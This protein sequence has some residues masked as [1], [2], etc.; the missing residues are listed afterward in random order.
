MY[1]D[2]RQ[3]LRPSHAQFSGRRRRNSMPSATPNWKKALGLQ[4]I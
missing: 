1:E 3:A 2:L 4:L